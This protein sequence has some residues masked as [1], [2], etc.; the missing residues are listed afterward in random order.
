VGHS[1]TVYIGI[2]ARTPPFGT[3]LNDTDS[4]RRT[5][6]FHAGT[7]TTIS[8]SRTWTRIAPAVIAAS[9]ALLV[10]GVS[11]AAAAPAAT[12]SATAD[13]WRAVVN[14]WLGN[15]R[16][17]GVYAIP[18]YTQAIQHLNAYP[19]VR[20]YSSA[21]DD[22][23]RALLA[24]IR[25]DRGNGPGAG[26]GPTDSNG[27][28]IGGGPTAGGPTLGG[29]SSDHN[30][31]LGSWGPSDATSIPLPLLVLGALALLL[32]AAAVA[33]WF[34]RRVQARRVTPTPPRRPAVE[35]HS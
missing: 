3:L 35:K 9:L 30:S 11:G 31:F 19:D 2:T 5:L 28:P 6:R 14:D 12:S 27:N 13:C 25:Q 7:R 23:Q 10:V 34:A 21:T 1:Q 32:L 29:P 22:I 8:K 18:C 26:P 4:V 17:D 16:V 33:T 15:S 20:S 24:A